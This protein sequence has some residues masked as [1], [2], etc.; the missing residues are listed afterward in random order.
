MIHNVDMPKTMTIPLK[1]NYGLIYCEVEVC[2]SS[3]AWFCNYGKSVKD[4]GISEA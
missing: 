2:D 1:I 4:T 3:K